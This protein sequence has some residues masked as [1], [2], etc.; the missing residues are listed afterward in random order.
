MINE[1]QSIIMFLI[2]PLIFA[3]WLHY[4]IHRKN[5]L[6]I[7]L[8]TIAILTS[9][10]SSL[11]TEAVGL[12]TSNYIV[13]L[14]QILY[15]NNNLFKSEPGLYFIA[16]LGMIIRPTIQSGLFSISLFI[17]GLVL[18]TIYLLHKEYKNFGLPLAIYV[19]FTKFFIL[20][21]SGLRQWMS[22]AV[23][24]F[25]IRFLLKKKPKYFFISVIIASLFHNSVII[26]LAMLVYYYYYEGLLSNYIKIS[27]SLLMKYWYYLSFG[28]FITFYFLYKS[29]FASRYLIYSLKYNGSKGLT[30]IIYLIL[31]FIL[32]LKQ[33]KYNNKELDFS[34][35][36][37]LIFT[38][39]LLPTQYFNSIGRLFWPFRI[40]EI[41]VIGFSSK[42]IKLN[43]KIIVY[44]I[45]FLMLILLILE[46]KGNGHG[47]IP[48]YISW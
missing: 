41:Y 37:L 11:R 16:K 25:G 18:Y 26:S 46:L 33:R 10:L 6:I 31:Y 23:L 39:I 34:V 47:I 29:G 15:K 42:M 3:I 19:Y 1:T 17:N 30:L 2:I 36:T 24:F 45:M 8:L 9:L 22:I 5:I 32:L 27:K 20:T 21:L 35:K 43:D 38:V 40:L 7:S 13:H 48:Y 4:N 14:N 28:F 12:D 44:T